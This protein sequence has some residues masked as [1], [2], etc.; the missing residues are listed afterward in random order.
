MRAEALMAKA[1]AEKDAAD[2][3]AKRKNAAAEALLK[4]RQARTEADEANAKAEAEDVAP[5]TLPRPM[6][7]PLPFARS[8][9]GYA[10]GMPWK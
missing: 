3:E 6:L 9:C 8:P 1:Q 7:R 10:R 4:E 5:I 2:A